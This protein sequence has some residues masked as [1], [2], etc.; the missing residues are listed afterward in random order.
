[1]SSI[2]C[3]EEAGELRCEREEDLKMRE[4]EEKIKQHIETKLMELL[5]TLTERYEME[6]TVDITTGKG[7]GKWKRKQS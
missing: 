3:W 5:K 7:M 2:V 1:L 6:V 4:L